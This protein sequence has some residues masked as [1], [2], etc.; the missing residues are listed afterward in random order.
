MSSI[1]PVQGQTPLQ[2]IISNPIQKQIP[3]DA[4]GSSSLT[5]TDKLDLSGVN[6]LLTL[7]KS[8]DVRVDKVSQIKAQINA[9]TYETDDKL[10]S[11]VDKLLE[12]VV[13]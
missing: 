9:G 10:N 13:E 8:N 2:R 11:A 12:D 5:P 4:A 6:S 7:L 1:G 3:A